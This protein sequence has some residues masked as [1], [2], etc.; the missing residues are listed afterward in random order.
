MEVGNLRSNG[1]TLGRENPLWAIL[2]T[3]DDD[4]AGPDRVSHLHVVRRRG[5][6]GSERTDGIHVSAAS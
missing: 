1:D 4:A 6:A 2:S 5:G 3:T